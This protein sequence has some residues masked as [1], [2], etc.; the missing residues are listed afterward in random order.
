MET[1]SYL[2]SLFRRG[3]Q[4]EIFVPY[5]LIHKWQNCIF[6]K[7]LYTFCHIAERMKF[8][9]NLDGKNSQKN[10]KKWTNSSRQAYEKFN[11]SRNSTSRI[12]FPRTS[13]WEST[14]HW[15]Q[16]EI[17]NL[18]IKI[19]INF[20][21]FS[22]EDNCVSISNT[23]ITAH[24]VKAKSQEKRGQDLSSPHVHGSVRSHRNIIQYLTSKSLMKS[25]I[26]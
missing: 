22:K 19:S 21:P 8:V 4:G 17:T 16:R 11:N 26:F 9:R 7:L 25:E 12:A 14:A 20:S 18:K 2:H 1:F 10:C 6:G 13:S 24:G 15:K 3:P 5:S 23:N